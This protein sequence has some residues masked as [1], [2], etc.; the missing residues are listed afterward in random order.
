MNFGQYW[1]NWSNADNILAEKPLQEIT[2]D[3]WKYEINIWCQ[4]CI[5]Q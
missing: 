5:N 3:K 2:L 1:G 4:V